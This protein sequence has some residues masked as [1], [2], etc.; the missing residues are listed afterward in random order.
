MIDYEVESSVEI[1]P[2]VQTKFKSDDNYLWDRCKYFS[3]SKEL[4]YVPVFLESGKFIVGNQVFAQ[5]FNEVTLI[6]INKNFK[7]LNPILNF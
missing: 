1:E 4:F 6:F 7:T 3:E 2:F 5:K